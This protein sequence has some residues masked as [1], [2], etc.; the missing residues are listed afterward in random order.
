MGSQT[1]LDKHI[2][3]NN[4]NMDSWIHDGFMDSQW[5]PGFTMD[6]W[7][8]YMSDYI[9]AGDFFRDNWPLEFWRDS[10]MDLDLDISSL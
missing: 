10:Q 4:I 3:L 1:Q 5:I 6:F 7:K 2:W 8:P 9:T